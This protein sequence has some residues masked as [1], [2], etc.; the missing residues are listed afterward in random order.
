MNDGTDDSADEYTIT[1]NVT[2]VNDPPTAADSRVTT[3]EDTPYTFTAA[4][5][6]FSDLDTGDALAGV[7]I[8]RLPQVGTFTLDSATVTTNQAVSRAAVDAGR[9]R[10]SPAPN[11]SG[12]AYA[13]FT[14]RVN[15]GTSDSI[16]EYTITLNVTEVNDPPT[17]AHNTVTTAEDTLYTFTAEDFNFSDPDDDA[18]ADV[19]I[20]RLPQVGTFALDGVAVTRNQAVVRADIDGGKLRFTPVPNAS[21][22]AYASFAFT[23]NDGTEDSA[24]E[25]TMTI[26]VGTVNDPPTAAHNTVTTAEDTP[27][28]FTA[29]DFN[30]SDPDTGDTLAGVKIASLPRVGTFALD[31]VAVTANQVVAR[32]DIDDGKLRFTPAANAYGDAYDDF[33]FT[34]NDGI[35]DSA[36][37]NMTIDVTAANDPP[38]A[39][40]N[41][42][43]TAEDAPYTFTAEDFNF[44]DPDT[45]DRLA[46]VKIVSPPPVGTLALD[47]TAVTENQTVPRADIDD[48]RLRFS[49]A[50][51]A[52]GDAY[53]D[54]TF[55][56]NDGI[57]DSAAEYTITLNVT[58]ANDPP[59][60]AHNT[61]ATAEDTPYTFTADDFNFSDPDTG[62]RLAS[63]KI[64][65]LPPVGTFTLDGVPVATNQ[66]VPRT[67]ID[68][69]KLIF[70]PAPNASGDVYANFAFKVNDGTEDS[71]AE[72]TV[73][74]GVGTANDP[75]T[76]A[77]SRVT[78]AEDTPYTF[79]ADDFNFSD[80]D[81]GDRLASVKIVRL[82]PVGTLALDDTAV[83]ENQ[84]VPRAD[85]DAGRLRFSPAPDASGDAYADFTFTVNDG[86]ED[87]AA[88]YTITLNVTAANDP[89]TAAH[90]TVATAEDTPYTFTADDFN[91]SDPDT[92]DRLAS[93]KIVRLPPVGTLA[94][95]DTAVTENQTVPRADIDAGKLRFSPAPNA[96]GDA[97]ADFTFTVNDGIEDSAAEYTITL[98]VTAANDPPTAAHNTVTTAEDTPYTFTADDFN[99]S[100]PDTGDR[101]A[102]VKIVTLPP[103]GTFTLDGVPVATNQVVPR[104]GID[105]GK[106]IFTP[107]PNASGDVYANFAF[108]VNDGTEDSAAEYTVTIGV[109]TANDPPT[110]ANSRVTTAEDTPYTFTAGD[111]NFSDPDGDALSGVRIISLPPVGT[112]A[113]DGATVTTNQVVPR[114]DIDAGKL[115]FTPA[116]NAY[117]DAYASFAFRVND[118]TSDSAANY[119]MTIDVTEVN[120]P[121][122]AAD[123]RVT[124]P[125]DT[126]YT[127]TADDFNFSDADTG[128]AL[129]SV[130]ITSLPRVGTFTLDG[131]TVTVNQA[132]P[133][134]D[135]DAGKLSFTP[136]PNASGNAYAS[137]TFRVNDGIEDS[138]GEYTMT[139]GVGTANDPPTAAHRTVATAEDTPYAFTAGDFSFSDPDG[140]ALSS[141][142]IVSLPRVGTFTL[143]GGAVTANQV[144]PRTGI[145][146][147][148]LIF[149]PAPNAYGDAYASF[150]FRV[151]DGT[152]DSAANYTMTIDVTEVNDPPT[153]A[154]SRVTTAEDNAYTFTAGD[155][156]FSDVDAGDALSSVKIISLPTAGTFTLDSA[157]VTA[158]QAVP[159]TDIDAGKLRFTPAP[160]ASGDPYASFIFKVSDGAVESAANYTM[161]IGIG[162]ANDPPTAA[163]NTVTTAEDNAYIFTVDDFNFSD[164]DGDTLSSVKVVS[165]PPVGT[166]AL[167]GATPTA[168]Q[169]VAKADIDAG[170]L[171]FTPA[172]N[173]GGAYAS[174]AFRVNDG[175]DDSVAHTMTVS[176]AAANDTPTSADKTVTTAEDTAYTFTADDFNFSDPD[177][178]DSLSG[179]KIV[180]LPSVGTL[181]LDGAALTANQT[182]PRADIDGGK[183]SFTPA[184]NAN[185][186]AYASF[187]FRVSDGT[188][189]STDEY[190]MT[191]DVTAVNDAPTGLP[192]VTGPGTLRAEQTLTADTTGIADADGLTKVA[193]SY[194]WVRVDGGT[195]TEI[196]DATDNTYRVVAAD[197]GK[198]IRVRVTFTDDGG[199]EEMLTS[200]AYPDD[201]DTGTGDAD[202]APAVT[203]GPPDAPVNLRAQPGDGQVAMTWEAPES[204]AG[205]RSSATRSRAAA[206]GRGSM[207]VWTC[208]KR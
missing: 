119:T 47:D 180:S 95:D 69:G 71:A 204:D 101:L 147:G 139:I 84:T 65:N 8:V 127:F 36:V 193:Y 85:I 188:D 176:V 125:E 113:L 103:V 146:A 88:E 197:Q 152:S 52:Y 94:L 108:K 133:R 58:A 56:V 78:T 189:D 109:G 20:A 3:P 121:P 40:H 154:D 44:S 173:T 148:K 198:K 21:G 118:G 206:A 123:S 184:P 208:V 31:G 28:T 57:E 174:F 124:T 33:T 82:P 12:D 6:N 91:F 51:D 177:A 63:V 161:T 122:T 172:A 67:G 168:N 105:G 120:D 10:F 194:Q 93:V 165:L 196:A 16:A 192:T 149:T 27:Y 96:S 37:H 111:F 136:A 130:K 53:D 170:K 190:A 185:G 15:D 55:T 24:A 66:V 9:L 45:G 169:V 25:Y 153:A 22:D 158:N 163:D 100:D 11:A 143:D 186:P 54:F 126:P 60:A 144:V 171:R 18:L 199:T 135:I 182:V 116:P 142:K 68:G 160:N 17:A 80:P 141:V 129:S 98:N 79:A 74:I 117:G 32:A 166:L 42:V 5:F 34:V 13:D 205:R 137:F 62:D 112:L 107:A 178:G 102:S 92:G 175:T 203:G 181:A 97:Y 73:T 70:T 145:D 155:F 75:P 61:V 99:F 191:M 83:T 202:A 201:N 110:A 76:A 72:Y 131:A 179:V 167:D 77:N 14:F 50:P 4:D 195:D 164:P 140:D 114:T 90:N 157:T 26:G 106:L 200:A 29:E 151:N 48:G 187:T 30:F 183:L 39:A 7:K 134:T 128:D 115:S 38:T 2:A 81:T 64:V 59:T 138:V 49:P 19:K 132:V 87:S 41:T 162:A 35:D 43:T 1:I 46:S 23:V 207:P 159:R 89:P 86:T 104:T 156:N 150:T